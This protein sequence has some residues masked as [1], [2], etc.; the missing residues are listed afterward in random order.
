LSLPSE[1]SQDKTDRLLPQ[2]QAALEG[3]QP[4]AVPPERKLQP[5]LLRAARR[6]AR[7]LLG[8]R[9]SARVRRH[10]LEPARFVDEARQRMDVFADELHG[11]HLRLHERGQQ[12]E[13]I[14]P[15]LH[16]ATVN[17]E[18]LKGE[19]RSVV[20]ALDDL[21]MAIAPAAG[22]AGA[23]VRLSELRERVNGLDRRLRSLMSTAPQSGRVA[24]GNAGDGRGTAAESAVFDYV[25][26]EQ[27]FRGDPALIAD[28]LADRYLNRLVDH[29]PVVDIGC[30]NAGLVA[31]LKARGVEAIGIDTDPSMVAEARAQGLD[32]RLV[33]G[34]AFLRSQPSASLGAI[35][36]THVVEHLE[37]AQLVELLELAASRLKPGGLFIAETPNPET[38]IVLGNSYILDPTHVRPLH[39]S[40]LTFLCEGAGFRDVRLQFYEPARDY[41]L[42]M[43]DDPDAPR[44]TEQV[45]KAFMT[46]NRV[47]FGPQEY[48]LIA[49]AA[50]PSNDQPLRE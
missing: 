19:I 30:G 21:G 5:A 45:N 46:L 32:V 48:A 3:I 2:R 36:T 31:M 1:L 18:L 12:I 34:A 11:V 4:Q 26:F 41:L 35:I 33:E 10:L 29:P 37:L 17:L 22:L 43:I 25:G 9:L 42:P 13:A 24:D 16:G 15:E 6:A 40:L 28:R 50:P 44:W 49:T 39:P 38:L 23:R 14:T 27:R 7:V 8:R 20:Q 47:L